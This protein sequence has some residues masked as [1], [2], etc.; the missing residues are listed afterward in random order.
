MAID[1]EFVIDATGD[2]IGL[3]QM[4]VAGILGDVIERVGIGMSLCLMVGL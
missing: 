4:S 3:L 2:L 1:F